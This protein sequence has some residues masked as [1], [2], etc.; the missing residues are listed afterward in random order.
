MVRLKRFKMHYNTCDRRIRGYRCTRLCLLIPGSTSLCPRHPRRIRQKAK[1]RVNVARW[2]RTFE[3]SFHLVNS[4]ILN[5][6]R[7]APR[8]GNPTSR[9][10]AMFYVDNKRCTSAY[11]QDEKIWWFEPMRE[12]ICID[13]ALYF[14][15]NKLI[16]I[17][18][19]S[20]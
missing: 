1:L 12:K 6:L 18:G 5:L 9:Q 17:L 2:S 4:S 20:M 11:A 7:S 16:R 19:I 13:P 3:I 15:E 14:F 8:D 10:R